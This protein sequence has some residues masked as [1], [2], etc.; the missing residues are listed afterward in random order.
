MQKRNSKQQIKRN[1]IERESAVKNTT[2]RLTNIKIWHPSDNATI[3]DIYSSLASLN[4][5][6]LHKFA[7]DDQSVIK[8]IFLLCKT[9]Y[10][11]LCMISIPAIECDNS[12]DDKSRH[13]AIIL[14]NET[15]LIVP[16]KVRYKY[17]KKLKNSRIAFIF[18]THSGIEG[19]GNSSNY[20]F[21]DQEEAQ[22]DL[23]MGQRFYIPLPLIDYDTLVH[24][25]E[26]NNIAYF[27]RQSSETA[28][29]NKIITN[30]HLNNLFES[31]G[32]YTVFIPNNQAI[33]NA[34]VNDGRFLLEKSNSDVAKIFIMN[35][36]F[37]G[38]FDGSHKG[39][40]TSLQGEEY[41]LENGRITGITT[42]GKEQL[43]KPLYNIKKK[44]GQIYII[45][46]IL[47][48]KNIIPVQLDKNIKIKISDFDIAE[49]TYDIWNIQ[50]ILNNTIYKDMKEQILLLQN[51][52]EQ[53]EQTFSTD[54]ENINKQI[55]KAS[56]N[57]QELIYESED[58]NDKSNEKKT[59]DKIDNIKTSLKD[60]NDFY[61]NYMTSSYK[62]TALSYDL[63]ISA[64]IARDI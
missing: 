35:H 18:L 17:M 61:N 38:K 11:H 36:T 42:E 49:M 58:E 56:D 31:D 44:N 4:F 1:V 57:I 39:K 6:I 30:A 24:S 50:H 55:I 13:N 15:A 12:L 41:I 62:L 3:G 34:Y 22:K 45:D 52:I 26:I 25:S 48:T 16:F 10:G 14:E 37:K 2:P 32:P 29:F 21:D 28:F 46:Y 63:M 20:I 19:V 7:I 59:F 54:I 23:N 43:G 64:K 8:C 9:S 40:I 5:D 60:D 33:K 27:I 53:Q 47:E 51:A